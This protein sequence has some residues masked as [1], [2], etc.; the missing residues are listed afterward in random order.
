M[1]KVGLGFR[2]GVCELYYMDYRWYWKR[3]RGDEI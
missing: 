3:C 1:D 2:V